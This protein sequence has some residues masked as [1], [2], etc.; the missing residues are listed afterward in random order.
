[1]KVKVDDAGFTKLKRKVDSINNSI[2][3]EYVDS[4]CSYTIISSEEIHDSLTNGH[5]EYVVEVSLPRVKIGDY[6]IWA[7]AYGDVNTTHTPGSFLG[8]YKADGYPDRVDD[9]LD[10]IIISECDHCDKTRK[11]V[12][13]YLVEDESTGVFLQVGSSCL[14]EFVGMSGK[15]VSALDKF[16]THFTKLDGNFA[17]H[18]YLMLD[19]VLACALEETRDNGYVRDVT[20]GNVLNRL[21]TNNL[22]SI[23]DEVKEFKES[24]L[25]MEATS[26]YVEKVKENIES[27][28]VSSDDVNLMISSVCLN[29]KHK[30]TYNDSFIGEVDS[31][32]SDLNVV[33]ESVKDYSDFF[34]YNGVDEDNHKVMWFKSTDNMPLFAKTFSS[35]DKVIISKAKVKKHTTFKNVKQ[36]QLSYVKVK[37]LE[38]V[39]ML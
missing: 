39:L 23:E 19:V 17:S 36:T 26:E 22:P 25:E 20:I 18:P 28:T 33:I 4:L 34:C 37:A 16:K 31:S 12:T 10:S 13:T 1:M 11:R 8:V 7:Y 32:I 38:A 14:A 5:V 21:S 30:R 15:A 6:T 27:F 3:I 29:P 9:I 35:G 2:I 24:V